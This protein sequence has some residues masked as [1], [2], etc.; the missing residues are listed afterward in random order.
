[1]TNVWDDRAEAYRKSPDH[2][3]GDDLDQLVEWCEPSEET[4]ILDVATGGGHVARRLRER[5]AT[6]VTL[7]PSPGMRPDVI[8][9]AEDLPFD[10]ASF[11]V[12]VTR[13]APHH[14]TDVRRAVAEFARVANRFVVIEDTLY[15][16]EGHEE[17]EKVRDPTHVRSYTEAEWRD[18]LEAVGLEVELVDFFEKTHPLDDWLARTGCE[19]DDAKRVRKLLADRLT[20]D[21]KAWTDTKILLRARRSQK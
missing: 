18:M 17:A 3:S 21:G 11:D 14:F 12:V 19:G 10:D 2:S 13:I 5:G 9:G 1:M 6:V 16:S 8:A 4:K 15:S 20:A 7:D